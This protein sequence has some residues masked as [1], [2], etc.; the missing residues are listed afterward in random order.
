MQSPII[1]DYL[2]RAIVPSTIIAE[3]RVE[4]PRPVVLINA[5]FQFWLENLPL[6]LTNI[7]GEPRNSIESRSRIGA[8]LELWLLKALEDY[9]LLTKGDS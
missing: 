6:L 1:S 4:H 5:G 7:K 2:R 9:P 8:R 3:G